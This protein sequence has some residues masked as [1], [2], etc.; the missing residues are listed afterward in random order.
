MTL[1]AENSVDP[2]V[3]V[4]RDSH[5]VDVCGGNDVFGHRDRL[6][7]EA[8]AVDAIGTLSHGKER[9]AV[10]TLYTTYQQVS[11]VEFDGSGIQHGIHHDA[12]HQVW[13]VLFR[14][15][16]SPLERCVF[17]GEDRE[18]VLLIDTISPRQRL[19]LEVEQLFVSFE[20]LFLS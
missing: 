15:I 2:S 11:A 9:L 3:F 14:K 13:V 10:S 8:E 20:Q 19:V 16:V 4:L 1:G 17:C 7:P 12:L 5:I 6:V 18:L